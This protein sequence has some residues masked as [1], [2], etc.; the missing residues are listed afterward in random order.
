LASY[1]ITA[2]VNHSIARGTQRLRLPLLLFQNQP[3]PLPLLLLLPAIQPL[4]PLSLLLLLLL[5]PLLPMTLLSQTAL[6][7]TTKRV[8][9]A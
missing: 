5:L 7:M 8:V 9:S 4:P 1:I 2:N 6:M 3:P